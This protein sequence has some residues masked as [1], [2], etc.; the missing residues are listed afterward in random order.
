MDLTFGGFKHPG[1]MLIRALK[2]V[3][4]GIYIDGPCNSVSELLKDQ[5]ASEFK[6]LKLHSW[7]KHDGDAFDSGNGWVHLK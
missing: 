4:D 6:D 2:R 1:G 5:G 3:S 7:P